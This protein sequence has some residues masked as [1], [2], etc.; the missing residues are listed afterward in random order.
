MSENIE[1]IIGLVLVIG[2]TYAVYSA[3]KAK[4]WV[5]KTMGYDYYI[6]FKDLE[7]GI[8]LNR[9]KVLRQKVRIIANAEDQLSYSVQ[10]KLNDKALKDYL[11]KTYNLQANQ[12]V[13][14]TEQ[15]SGV[16]GMV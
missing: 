16:L 6:Q 8:D 9:D 12:V 15:L 3:F 7:K 2:M 1:G 10:S 13:V 11:I 5:T 4:L 14:Q